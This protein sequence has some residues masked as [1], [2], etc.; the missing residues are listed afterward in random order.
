MLDD[1]L[2]FLAKVQSD[3]SI[4]ATRFHASHQVMVIGSQIL[5]ACTKIRTLRFLAPEQPQDV[6]VEEEES[7][8]TQTCKSVGLLLNRMASLGLMIGY[9]PIS[10]FAMMSQLLDAGMP[11]TNGFKNLCV[12]EAGLI[13]DAACLEALFRL[14]DSNHVPEF[15][16]TQTDMNPPTLIQNLCIVLQRIKRIC[17]ETKFAC[18]LAESLLCL[19]IVVEI[20]CSPW[21][22]E[23]TSASG[24]LSSLYPTSAWAGGLVRPDDM[25]RPL[26]SPYDC[27]AGVAPE[28]PLLPLQLKVA[29]LAVDLLRL[30][31]QRYRL[32]SRMLYNLGAPMFPVESDHSDSYDISSSEADDPAQAAK[33]ATLGRS[34]VLQ[35][36]YSFLDKPQP[37]SSDHGEQWLLGEADGLAP[38][39]P[40]GVFKEELPEFEEQMDMNDVDLLDLEQALQDFCDEPMS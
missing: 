19:K 25:H 7:V 38:G 6:E 13:F 20:M 16:R 30:N 40:I 8:T 39:A 33:R 22:A 2:N 34:E 29:L 4:N 28:D 21:A 31:A 24:E 5:V 11:G 37:M 32:A 26:P 17:E 15:V 12:F 27:V 36:R 9:V 35:E 1:C 14:S 23:Q 18:L 10:N 3:P